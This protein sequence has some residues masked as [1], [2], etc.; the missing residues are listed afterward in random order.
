M[1][2]NI[3]PLVFPE[4]LKIL[5]EMGHG[6]E[7]VFSDAHF[8]AYSFG[9]PV[10]RADGCSVPQMLDAVLPLLELD[11]YV[12]APAVMMAP[13][14][15]DSLDMDYV[16]LCQKSVAAHGCPA[17]IAHI[18]RFAFYE[19]TKSVFAVVVTGE[20]RKYGNILLKKGV[21]R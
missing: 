17:K 20:T 8:P 3:S 19:R 10:L 1:L 7:I 18:D 11:S 13:V 2:K 21:T 5:S 9:R 12:D 16:A 15:G 14:P 4:L 6:D